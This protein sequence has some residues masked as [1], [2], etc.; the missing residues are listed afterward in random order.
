MLGNKCEHVIRFLEGDIR[1]AANARIVLDDNTYTNKTW[2]EVSGISVQEIHIMEVEF[3][4]NMRYTLYASAVEWDRWHEKL[5]QFW[6][7]FDKASRTPPESTNKALGHLT[8]LINMQPALPSPPAS[9]HASPPFP[10]NLSPNNPTYPHPLSMPPYLAPAIPSPVA[11]MPDVDLRP[12]AR[13]RSYDDESQEPPAK[14]ITRPLAPPA[15]SS[16]T[17]A[18]TPSSYITPRL[19]V[20]NLSISTTNHTGS[21]PGSYSAHLPPP[22]ARSMST[23]YPGV[24]QWPQPG[25]LLTPS[26]P[27]GP[28]G[29]LPPMTDQP[30]R[31]APYSVGSR[32]SSPTSGNFPQTSQ[33]LLSPSGFP[34]QRSSPYK[35]LRGVNTLLVPPPSASMHNPTLNFGLN[36]MHYQ[37][38]G[39]P[40]SERKSGVVPYMHHD[41]WL[42][43]QQMPHW[44]SLAPSTSQ[45]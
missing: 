23:V 22:A 44:S 1:A 26:L 31:Q 5:G 33:E 38:L 15:L 25:N 29:N 37:P 39:K 9:F 19:P 21:F 45:P 4:S 43:P 42:Q 28:L 11:P 17:M 7:Y 13:K 41:A 36:R 6:N 35:P 16:G 8:P 3:L 34:T 24:S 27:S 10:T 20:P 18:P 2:A 14:R 40:M 30:P 32:T 12:T